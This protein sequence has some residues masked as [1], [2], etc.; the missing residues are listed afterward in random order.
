MLSWDAYG[1]WLEGI[2]SAVEGVD[3][4]HPTFIAQSPNSA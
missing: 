1:L 3:L 4:C 2:G